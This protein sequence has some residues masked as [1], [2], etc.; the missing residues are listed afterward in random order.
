MTATNKGLSVQSEREVSANETDDTTRPG[1]VFR[2]SVPPVT[3]DVALA[4]RVRALLGCVHPDAC[5]A[6][7]T[8]IE[9]GHAP[10]SMAWCGACGAIGLGHGESVA[11]V[12][13]GLMHLLSE[14]FCA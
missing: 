8:V 9:S 13:A 14:K 4:E 5:L 1:E 6:K 10:V 7:A 12:R 2:S 3:G 11:W